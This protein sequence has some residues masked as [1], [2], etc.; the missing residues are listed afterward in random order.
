LT[1]WVV[2]SAWPYS[3]DVP[4]LGNLIGSVLSADVFARFLRLNGESVVFVSGSDEHGTP[5]EVEALKRGIPVRELADQ[6][7]ARISRLFKLWNISYDNYT[8]TESPIHKKYVREVYSQIYSNDSYIF[9]KEERINYCSKDK[10]FL[11]DRFVEGNCPYCGYERARGDQCENCGRILDADKLVDAHCVICGTRTVLKETKQWFFDLPKLSNY[12]SEYLDRATLSSN[13]I[14]F[15]KGWLKEG[16]RPRSITRDSEWGIK[17]PFPGAESKTIYVWMEAILGYPSA[18]I[19]FF[20]EKEERDEWEKY[21]RTPGSKTSFFIGKDNI[22]FHAIILPALLHATGRNYNE[23][24]LISSTEFLLFE[25]QKFSKSR[26]IGIWIDEALE[27]LPTDYWRYSLISLRPESGD[28]NFGWDSLVEKINNDLNDTIGNFVNRTL[29]GVAKFA[30]NN[31]NLKSNELS[32]EFVSKIEEIIQR[33]EHIRKMY[34]STELQA[35]CRGS[36]DQV[37]K[38]NGFLSATEPWKV[39]KEDRKRALEIFYVS[40]TTLKASCSELSPIIPTTV[41]TIIK[42]SGLFKNQNGEPNWYD[43]NLDND[44]PLVTREIKPIFQKVSA[45]E[46][47]GKLEKLRVARNRGTGERN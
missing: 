20:E 19:E 29:V 26:K 27:I 10:R 17:A 6:N 43:T 9:T 25:G 30:E 13:V 3:S 11:P 4:H 37:S 47:R 14:Q 40:L 41:E 28:I 42:Q 21:W 7:H 18:T 46:L 36:L 44:L 2:T 35:A 38:A 24:S 15:S 1:R 16:L 12:I 34:F 22:P 8:R 45:K 32:S 39:V 31:F 5:L 33:H 23:P